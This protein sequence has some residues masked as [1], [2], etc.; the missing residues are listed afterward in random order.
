MKHMYSP[1]LFSLLT[2][3]SPS[4]HQI[5]IN[6]STTL[7]VLIV[8]FLSTTTASAFTSPVYHQTT[9]HRSTHIKMSDDD[10]Y[11]TD[12]TVNIVPKFKIKEGMRDK[13]IHLLPQF[14]ELVKANEGDSCL[15]YGFVSTSLY[16][17][18]IWYT[19]TNQNNI[20]VT[21]RT[22]RRWICH[23]S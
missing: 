5:M 13:F 21:G 22:H 10:W 4:A 16:P 3:T 12:G 23:L 14:M 20:D 8:I 17:I 19:Y 18:I 2:Y 11:E 1:S 9:T 15:Y 6:I 7:I